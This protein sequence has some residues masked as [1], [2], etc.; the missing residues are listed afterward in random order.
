MASNVVMPKLSDTMESG[1]ILKW[2]KKE[3]DAVEAGDILAEVSTDKADMEMEA[4]VSGV[5]RKILIPEGKTAKVGEVLAIIGEE[6]EEI[7]A[8]LAIAPPAEPPQARKEPAKA[9]QGA[10]GARKEVVESPQQEAEVGPIKA[11]PLAR[12]IAAEKGIDL[13]RIQGSGPGGRIIEK[14]LEGAL[15]AK[16]AAKA[17]PAVAQVPAGPGEYREE[18]MSLM[19]K[20]IARRMTESKTTVPHFYLAME[21]DMEAAVHIRKSLNDLHPEAKVSFNDLIV[22]A[23]ALALRKHPRV[24]ASFR[25]EK[26]RWN[27]AIDV[28]VAVALED[29][30]IT[31]I[32]RRCDTKN[33]TEIATEMQSLAEKARRKRLRPEEYQGG[34]FTISNLGM[35]G[36]EN[37]SAIINP[38]EGAVLAVGAILQKPAVWEGEVVARHRMKVTLSCDHRVVDGASGALFLQELKKL[39][40][41]PV[42]L[43]L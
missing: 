11:S 36:V 20:T 29:G 7:S 25:G 16:P 34:T 31:P 3:G 17:P 37:F 14:D 9:P 8:P 4:Y 12:K 39:L 30:L 2:V 33:L 42:S 24:N 38:P 6:G 13:S 10:A 22:R 5:L 18:D 32:I 21:I 1:V 43:L 26:I 27:E 15:A 23:V 19:R 40:E 28:G 41:N 35:Y